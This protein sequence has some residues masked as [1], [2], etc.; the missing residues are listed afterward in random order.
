MQ[1]KGEHMKYK[2]HSWVNISCFFVYY[3]YLL[4]VILFSKIVGIFR[5]NPEELYCSI[6]QNSQNTHIERLYQCGAA[7]RVVVPINLICPVTKAEKSGSDSFSN[8]YS[9]IYECIRMSV[10]YPFYRN[11]RFR[12]TILEIKNAPKVKFHRW[13]KNLQTKSQFV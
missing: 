7:S 3:I 4:G 11:F 9:R 2:W 10:V 12:C 13:L 1:T 8:E 6:L 5:Y